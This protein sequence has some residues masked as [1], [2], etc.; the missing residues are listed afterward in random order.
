MKT[1]AGGDPAPCPYPYGRLDAVA[2]AALAA[3]A[4]L[5]RLPFRSSI[6]YAWDSVNYAFALRDFDLAAEQ[7]QPP[8]YIVYVWLARLVDAGVHDAN[9]AMVWISLVAGALAAAVA[10]CLGR[11]VAGRAAGAALG[12]LVATSPL[13]WFYGE[14][15]LPHGLDLLLVLTAAW[16]LWHVRRGN[17]ALLVPAAAALAVAGGVRPQTLVFLLPLAVWAAWRAPRRRWLTA[18]AVGAA[19]CL[20]WAVPLLWSAGGPAEYV[21]IAQAY[22]ARFEE[23]TSVLRG[24]GL[25]GVLGNLE[26]VVVDTAYALAAAWLPLA[27]ALALWLLGRR[28][29]AATLGLDRETALFLVLWLAPALLY[30]VFIHMGQQGMVFTYLPALLLPAA[31]AVGALLAKRRLVAGIAVLAA[32]NAAV[33]LAAPEHPRWAGDVRVPARAAI[34]AG[35][36]FYGER[37]AA[38][39][40]RFAADSSAV[41]AG[42]WRHVEYYLPA[43]A[44]LRLGASDDPEG[45]GQPR[46]WPGAGGVLTAADLGLDEGSAMTLVLFDGTAEALVAEPG[47]LPAVALPSDDELPYVEVPA[48]EAVRYEPPPVTLVPAP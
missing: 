34:A 24:A 31:A 7:P 4:A 20:V 32:L 18:V 47:A 38:I 19:I 25:E 8:G 45:A 21:D 17:D 27:F 46:D 6:L 35:D 10:Y 29:L 36:A 43:Y 11:D 22:S 12:V 14:I 5:S 30:Y 28:R 2:M 26:K 41:V 1:R 23:S 42:D 16:L 37:F 40:E 39:P 13:V 44:L 15:A 48:G 33:F 9:A 3:F